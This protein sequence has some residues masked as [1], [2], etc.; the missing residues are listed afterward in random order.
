[1]VNLQIA[2][3]KVGGLGP[4]DGLRH[5]EATVGLS[6]LKLAVRLGIEHSFGYNGIDI[7]DVMPTEKPLKWPTFQWFQEKRPGDAWQ[8][9]DLTLGETYLRNPTEGPSPGPGP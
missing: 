5:G 1:M 7:C 3:R 8:Q 4:P 6:H 9:G 2:N